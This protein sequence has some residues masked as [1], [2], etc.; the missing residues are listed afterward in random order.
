MSD[1][2]TLLDRI[3]S[4]DASWIDYS[5]F[6]SLESKD[7]EPFFELA[8]SITKKNFGNTI[9]IYN[10]TKKFPA[11]SITGSEC[12]LNCEHCSK[13]YLK[14]MKQ[15]LGEKDLEQFLLDLSKKDGIGAL[16]SGGSDLDGSIP[17]LGFLDAI[18]KVK[19]ETDLIINT[20]TGLLKEE[21]AK[22]L[23]EAKV[24]I[25][26]FDINMDEEVIR[27]IYHLDVELDE[28][29]RAIELLQK[30]NLSVVPHVCVGLHYG[31]L[32]KEIESLKFIKETLFN[33]S[34][35]VVIALI[36]PKNSD[37]KFK[38]P[39]PEVIAKVIALIRFIFPNTEISLGC[40][41]P[42][43]N[44]KLEVEKYALRAGITRIEIPSKNTIKWLR[45]QN[46]GVQFKFFSA[47]CAIPKKYEKLAESKKSDIKRY[48]NI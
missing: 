42:R 38:T 47:C 31:Q 25:V 1:N 11:I 13:K 8:Q 12:A 44:I 40:M 21:T 39:E 46:S 36:P 34:L 45:K 4:G 43:G 10:P 19:K 35:I 5:E 24:D 20:H 17:L 26:S 15:I 33:P 28:Y 27:N 3:K 23:T 22:K 37:I 2:Q 16:I 41:R 32:H 48:L 14:G 30:Y 7:L 6:L 29:R 18:K 9:K